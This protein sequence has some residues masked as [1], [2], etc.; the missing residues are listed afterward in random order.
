MMYE[1]W[2][3]E[4]QEQEKGMIID[5]RGFQDR[6]DIEYKQIRHRNG[7][8]EY[9]DKDGRIVLVRPKTDSAIWRLTKM[10]DELSKNK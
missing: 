7:M 9:L 3:I 4:Q 10:M 8:A 2:Q 6:F 5:W 1:L